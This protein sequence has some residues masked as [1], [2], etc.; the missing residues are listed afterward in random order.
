MRLHLSRIAPLN[1]PY[2]PDVQSDFHRIMRGKAPLLLF[3]VLAGNLRAWE[4]FRNGALLDGRVLTLRKREIVINRTCALA[5]CEYEWGVH[6]ATFAEAS[7][8][9]EAEIAATVRANAGAPCWSKAEQALVAGGR[10]IAS[11]SDAC[12]RRIPSAIGALR[13]KDGFGNHPAVRVLPHGVLR[14]ERARAASRERGCAF[15]ADRFAGGLTKAST[16]LNIFRN[17]ER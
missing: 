15:P 11:P 14:R 12:R 1:P 10:R 6:V 17:G 5:G 3:R 8:L 4:K 16:L 2:P 7:G 9:S 13:P